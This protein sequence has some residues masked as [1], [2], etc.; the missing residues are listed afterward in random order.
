MNFITA[1]GKVPSTPRYT[2]SYIN[3]FRGRRVIVTDNFP[4]LDGGDRYG[5]TDILR[6][7]LTAD[8]KVVPAVNEAGFKLT[9][10]WKTR[11]DGSS[12]ARAERI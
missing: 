9:G 11:A 7:P 2:V 4:H 12:V 8:Q 3:N 5:A 10:R 6:I 1:Q